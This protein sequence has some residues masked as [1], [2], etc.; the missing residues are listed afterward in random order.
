M[1]KTQKTDE[2][3]Q[4]LLY[5]IVIF[6]SVLQTIKKW[7]SLFPLEIGAYVEKYVIIFSN[8]YFLLIKNVKSIS[9]I[10]SNI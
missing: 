5:K 9:L 6:G 8:K 10:D 4:V 1:N 3:L 2:F 7:N